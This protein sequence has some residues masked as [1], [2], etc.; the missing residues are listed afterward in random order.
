MIEKVNAKSFEQMV[1]RSSKS[2]VIDV[3][4]P[5]C[6]PCKIMEPAFKSAAQRFTG[7]VKFLK[8]N[9]D[10]N[11]DLVKQYKIMGIPT[12][13]LFNH[14]KLVARKTGVQQEAAIVRQI[15]PLLNMS[16]EEAAAKEITGAW[17][18]F[19]LNWGWILG[20]AASVAV[21]VFGIIHA[22]S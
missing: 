17:G 7:Q 9:A 3:W 1:L 13:L 18:G 15:T 4:A 16:A 8:L 5:W 19:H 22:I 2:V 10:H 11:Q 21:L 6:G 20:I 14:G 12:L